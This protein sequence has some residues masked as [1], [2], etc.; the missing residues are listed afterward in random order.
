MKRSKKLAGFTLYSIAVTIFFLY[1]LFPSEAVTSYMTNKLNQ[2]N[3]DLSFNIQS[4]VTAFLV[5]HDGTWK[6]VHEHWSRFPARESDEK[7][8]R[9][10]NL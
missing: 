5:Q 9:H 3:S 7:E 8:D 6:I 4:R 1:Y 2:A 10:A